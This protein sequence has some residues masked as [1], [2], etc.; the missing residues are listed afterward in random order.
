VTAYLV[1]HGKAGD[2]ADWKRDDRLRPLSE[3]GRRQANALVG[4][5]NGAALEAILSSPYLRCVQTVE[6]LAQH[7]G[8]SVQSEPDLGE[9][10]GGTRLLQLVRRLASRNVA[11]CTHGDVLEEFLER[12]IE[13][14]V[15]VR[16]GARLDKGSTWVI[17]EANGRITGARYIAA[18]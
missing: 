12:L 6:P 10:V 9:G 4:L 1:R 18:P 8:L 16:A 11:L 14:G 17:S 7:F 5:L 3:A 13:D 15:V 2:R